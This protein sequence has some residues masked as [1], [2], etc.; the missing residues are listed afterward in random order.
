FAIANACLAFVSGMDMDSLMIERG[1]CTHALI[2]DAENANPI[3]EHT[4]ARLSKPETTQEQFRDELASMTLG[5]GAVAMVLSHIDYAPDAP[6]YLGGVTRSATQ[7][8]NLCRGNLDK[9]TT[10]TKQLMIAGMALASETWHAAQSVLGWNAQDMD[11][12]ICHQVSKPHTKGIVN[13]LGLDASKIMTIFEDHGNLG[14]AS[15]PTVLSKLQ[16]NEK[17]HKGER[18]ALLGIG[19]GLNC[20]MAEICW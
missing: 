14:P 5:S 7:W 1:A 20:T 3:Y 19:S 13:Q 6:R 11:H 9:M 4:L 10:N 18:I 17:L 16:D 2:V 15:V 8:H 12:F